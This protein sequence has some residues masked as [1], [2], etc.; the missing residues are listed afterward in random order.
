MGLGWNSN[1]DIDGGVLVFDDKN[2]HVDTVDFRQLRSHLFDISHS[3]DILDGAHHQKTDGDDE[4]VRVD[5]KSL[6]ANITTLM[7][8]AAIFTDGKTWKDVKDGRIRLVDLGTQTEKCRY[9]LT[10]RKFGDT[11]A[12]VLCK[13]YKSSRDGKWK[14]MSIGEPAADMTLKE[15][16]M[17][18]PHLNPFV[19]ESYTPEGSTVADLS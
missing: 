12:V 1:F 17:M 19:W 7:F 13:V 3:G 11:R 5:L 8:C 10:P 9:E 6:P 15:P 2:Q 14:M 18:L 4:K 16:R